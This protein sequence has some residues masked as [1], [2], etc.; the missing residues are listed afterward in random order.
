M[1]IVHF[2]LLSFSGLFL[3]S[4]FEKDTIILEDFN[5]A[6]HLR[7]VIVNDGVMGG[8]SNSKIQ[9]TED[10]YGWFSGNLSLRNNGGFASTRAMIAGKDLSQTKKIGIRIKGDGRSYSLRFRTDRN[11]DGIAY[12]VN[13]DTIQDEWIELDWSY[14]DFRPTF[15]GR[16]VRAPELESNTIR[17]MSIMLSDGL[18]GEFEVFIDWVKAY[19]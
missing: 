9:I 13:F 7:W 5:P 8:V 18:E 17:Q 11:L 3:P 16:T 12:A 19:Y 1:A 2:L 6:S 10:N 15:R 4:Q 14:S